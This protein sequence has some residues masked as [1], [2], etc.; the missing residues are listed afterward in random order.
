MKNKEQNGFDVVGV[1]LAAAIAVIAVW[2]AIGA[3]V[4]MLARG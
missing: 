1:V 4:R 3:A 2:A